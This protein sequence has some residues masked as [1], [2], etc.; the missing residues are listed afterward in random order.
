MTDL[1]TE[2]DQ[3]TLQKAVYKWGHSAQVDMAVEEMAEA[4]VALQHHRR[5]RE[6]RD[7]LLKELADVRIMWEQMALMWD[8]EA[9]ER[10][11]REKMDR[12][13]ERLDG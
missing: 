9:I 7:E 4:I 6:S 5:G 2:E 1:F 8:S 11:V 13:E 12:L 3:E 10:H